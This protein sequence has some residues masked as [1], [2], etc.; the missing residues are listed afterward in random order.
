MY[1][2][3]REHPPEHIHIKYGEYEAVMEL[4]N[5]NIIDGAI[6]KKCRQLVREWAESHQ[7]ELL[8]MWQTKTS[9][10]LPNWMAE[11]ERQIHRALLHTT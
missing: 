8:E 5:L 4:K 3:E 11:N 1:L 2:I 9:I 7:E 6:P 10:K